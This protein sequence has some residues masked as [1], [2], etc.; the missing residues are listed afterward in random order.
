MVLDFEKDLVKKDS[1]PEHVPVAIVGSGPVGLTLGLG[2][3]QWGI[4][5]L[6]LG[7]TAKLSDGSRAICV[8]RHTLQVFDWLG[9]VDKMIAKGVTWTLGRVF[10]GEKELFQIRFPGQT[11]EKFP[12]FINLQQYYTEEYLIETIQ[13][14]PLCDLRWKHKVIAL[15]QTDDKVE[16]KVETPDGV[17][18]VTAE[19]VIAA[20]GSRSTMRQ[21]LDI[22]FDGKTYND[23]FLIADI[24]ADL[25]RPNER[26]FWFDPVFNRGKSALVHPQPD[27]VWR[28]D[29]QLGPD[30]DIEAE[31]K[32]D[33][34][35]KR[36]REV[37]GDIPYE[38]EWSSIYTFHQRTASTY[39]KNRVFLAGDAA[40]LMSPF[41]ARGMNSGVQDANNLIWKLAL[42]L[43]NQAPSTLLDSYDSERRAAAFENL[44]ITN[45]SMNFITPHSPL[46]LRLRNQILHNSVH[47]KPLR[48]LVNSGRLSQPFAY[49]KSKI[50]SH[51]AYLPERKELLQSPKLMRQALAFLKAVKPG[52]LVPDA[53]YKQAEQTK[54]FQDLLGHNFVALYFTDK[55][56]SAADTAD[57]FW[58]FAPGVPLNLYLVS[59]EPAQVQ[60]AFHWQTNVL[61]DATGE[62]ARRYGAV[63]GSF[64]LIRPDG[65]LAVR[66]MR[67]PLHKLGYCLRLATAAQPAQSLI[68]P[69]KGEI[70][71]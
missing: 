44:R 53:F 56:Q 71:G 43:K 63:N 21:L 70:H 52:F 20:D 24:K 18:L 33:R 61:W 11:N 29:W 50:I 4:A 58:R 13:K 49:T 5:T 45:E 22:S 59:P 27:N 64:F 28:I 38:I 46:R 68:P 32:P 16:L 25:N 54:R 36:I 31:L 14:Q 39:R 7:A 9:A 15:S 67:F 2:L 40:H 57:Q 48:K 60:G 10:F 42:V 47:F 1:L 26:W 8:Q 65:H 62:F 66:G 17:K 3:A 55:P 23:R 41:G 34:L 69:V 51:Q 6:V 35:D 12:P 30:I 37:I 19:Y